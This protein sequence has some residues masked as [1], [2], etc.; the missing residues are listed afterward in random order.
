MDIPRQAFLSHAAGIAVSLHVCAG[1][2]ITLSV[3]LRLSKE[4]D[5]NAARRRRREAWWQRAFWE[6]SSLGC[7]LEPRGFKGTFIH[8]K[9]WL[10]LC[11]CRPDFDVYIFTVHT[12]IHIVSL[13]V[14]IN[15]S[16]SGQQTA[17]F[18]TSS[19][20]FRS[21]EPVGGSVC[22]GAHAAMLADLCL[23]YGPD[24]TDFCS[25]C[26][27]Q[28]FTKPRFPDTCSLVKYTEIIYANSTLFLQSEAI[29]CLCNH[30]LHRDSSREGSR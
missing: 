2:Q 8:E 27:P 11:V 29:R 7:W 22:A 4:Q 20:P 16:V 14:N 5:V 28:L 3:S 24:T 23:C 30:L 6:R 12:Y 17:G 9:I 18:A 13:L 10:R 1:V 21:F 19:R 15:W 25:C 26:W